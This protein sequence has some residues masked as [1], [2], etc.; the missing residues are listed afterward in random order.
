MFGN[1]T[2]IF[3]RA[4]LQPQN[5][6]GIQPQYGAAMQHPYNPVGQHQYTSNQVGR[7]GIFGRA[8]SPA[9]SGPQGTH[10][11]QPNGQ[12]FANQQALA[13]LQAAEQKRL[14]DALRARQEAEAQAQHEDQAAQAQGWYQG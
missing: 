6:K 1:I 13:A 4:L 5:A 10:N 12:Q 7:G 8:P 2:G 3:N 14:A 9:L 11:Y